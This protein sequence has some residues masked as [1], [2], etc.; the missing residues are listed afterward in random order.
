MEAQPGSPRG[1]R[2][3]RRRPM[4]DINVVPYIDVMLVLL[5]IFM[6]VAPVFTQGVKIDLPPAPSKAVD[7]KD[8]DNPLLVTVRGDGALF[9]NVGAAKDD[10]LG[11]RVTLDGLGDDAGRVI[12]ARPDVPVFVRGD[13]H[14]A[15]GRVIEVMGTLQKAGAASVGLLT[16]PPRVPLP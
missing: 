14:I 8:L 12:R 1:T 15:Y 9:I 7:P 16:S 4:A 2:R 5:V 13:E 11:K 3:N 6:A 10:E